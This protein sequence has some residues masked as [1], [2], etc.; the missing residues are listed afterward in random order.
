MSPIRLPSV[1]APYVS[2]SRLRSSTTRETI[3]IAAAVAAFA[4]L[5]VA[6]IG[7]AADTPMIAFVPLGLLGG[8]LACWIIAAAYAG[9]P[10]AIMAYFAA[11]TF[12]TDAQFRV[13]GAGD[14]DADW[15]S[16]LKFGLWIGA[17]AIGAGHLPPLGRMLSRPGPALWLAYIGIALLSSLYSPVPGYSFGCAF[18]LLCFIAFAYALITRLSESQIFWTFVLTLTVF[19]AISWVVFYVDPELGTSAAWTTGGMM[20]RMCGIA[21]Q[22]TNLGE[23]CAKYIGAAF[24]LWWAGRCRLFL[25]VIFMAFGTVTLVA[26]DC[27]TMIISVVVGIAAVVASRS[28]WLLAGGVLAALAGLAVFLLVPH[29]ADALGAHFSRSG[30]ATE[31]YTL[32]GRLEIWDFVWQQIMEKPILGWGYNS[33]KVVLGQH[34]G[35]ANGLMVDSAHNLFLQSL[36]SVGFIGTLPLVGVLLL[37]GARLLLRPPPLVAYFSIIVMI[38]AVSD[39]SAVGTTPTLMTLLFLMVS[40]WPTSAE[41]RRASIPAWRPPWPATGSFPSAAALSLPRARGR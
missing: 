16:L 22:A 19:N 13:R 17:G 29:L 2:W 32:T 37:L 27:R 4:A 23:V 41:V 25:A 40:I 30:D 1:G 7:Y 39:T 15:Q 28:V 33:S 11:F 36:L 3:L 31:L 35:F 10:A 8:V 5:L 34:F 24:L 38:G 26:S 12:I 6:S 9:S 18:T 14:I 20:Y 21:G